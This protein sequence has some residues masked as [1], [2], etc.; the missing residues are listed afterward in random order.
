MQCFIF[1]NSCVFQATYN[2]F[3]DFFCEF[4]NNYNFYSIFVSC[5]YFFIKHIIIKIS[6]GF[7]VNCVIT[8]FFCSFCFASSLIYNKYLTIIGFV[9]NITYQFLLVSLVSEKLNNIQIKTKLNSTNYH[10]I[11]VHMVICKILISNS[12]T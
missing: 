2:Q 10:T 5:N 7:R 12:S 9:N 6:F 3:L 1:Y 11:L 4:H 8:I